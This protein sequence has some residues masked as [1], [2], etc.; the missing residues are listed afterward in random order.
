LQEL[1]KKLNELR[2]EM[3]NLRREMR[4]DKPRDRGTAPDGVS[5]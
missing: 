5:R 4:P 3:D 1:E 2:K